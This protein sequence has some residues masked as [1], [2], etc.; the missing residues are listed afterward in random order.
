MNDAKLMLL[1]ES[2]KKSGWVAAALNLVCPGAGYAY[3]GRWMLGAIVFL[4]IIGLLVAS[5]KEPE[6][7]APFAIILAIDGF[8]AAGRYNKK[9]I[10]SVLA[11][12]EKTGE[13]NG[14]G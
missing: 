7:A 12:A 9:M 8:L 3:C 13:A 1:V 4:I 6:A 2:K 11:N 10:E 5:G 14:N